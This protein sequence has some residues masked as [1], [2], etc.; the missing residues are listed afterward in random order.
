MVNQYGMPRDLRMEDNIRRISD[1]L[2]CPCCIR[3]DTST[4]EFSQGFGSL[5][6]NV[7]SQSYCTCSAFGSVTIK[8]PGKNY[9]LTMWE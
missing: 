3:M 2:L 8:C 1:C 5:I 6:F 4:F 7:L 9:K